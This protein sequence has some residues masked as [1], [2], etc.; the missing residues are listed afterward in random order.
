TRWSKA[1][2]GRR[3]PGRSPSAPP[4]PPRRP[5]A[6]AAARAPCTPSSPASRARPPRP[7]PPAP[8][9]QPGDPAGGDLAGRPRPL[10]RPPD[11]VVEVLGVLRPVQVQPPR[12]LAGATGIGPHQRVAA[13]HPPEWVGRL[14]HHVLVLVDQVVE[15][16]AVRP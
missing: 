8:Q 2:P 14:P 10:R 4:T 6:A 1:H 3:L 16:E 9:R 15:R 13:R 11:H 12:R 5:G 7:P